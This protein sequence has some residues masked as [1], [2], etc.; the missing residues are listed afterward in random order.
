MTR[1]ERATT[2]KAEISTHFTTKQQVFLDFVL[3]HYVNVG[4]EE[5]APEKLTP[6]LRLKYKNS[7]P[8]AVSELGDTKQIRGVFTRFQ[9]FLY[10]GSAQNPQPRL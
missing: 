7:I 9:R 4:V 8:D 3:S 10:Q 1:A 5:L 2:A 6:L